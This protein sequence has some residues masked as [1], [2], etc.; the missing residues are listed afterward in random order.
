LAD[1]E[2]SLVSL[3]SSEIDNA[4]NLML[5]SLTISTEYAKDLSD[6]INQSSTGMHSHSSGNDLLVTKKGMEAQ[7]RFQG[8]SFIDMKEFFK[9]SPNA[10]QKKNGGWY[11]IVPIGQNATNLKSSS[12][13]SLWNQM[14]GMDFGKTGSLSDGE[15]NFL[16][17]SSNQDQSNVIN[18]LN[19]NWKSA[20]VTRVAS[21]TGNGSRG[22]YI[23]FR[24]VSDKSDPNSWLVGREAFTDDNTG[25]EQQED[26]A[27]LMLSQIAKYN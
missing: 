21:K 3:N 17:Q 5:N 10:K 18:P 16:E 11:L 15:T 13:R 7:A 26:I 8:I 23:S 27:I 9:N 4:L 2:N 22:H 25:P 14:S 20:N 6:W 19:Y 24:T 12:P 1:N